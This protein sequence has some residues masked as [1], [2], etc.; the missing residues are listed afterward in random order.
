MT[1]HIDHE[2]IVKSIFQRN[3]KNIAN[4]KGIKGNLCHCLTA[5]DQPNHG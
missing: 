5:G 4:F 1:E 3:H 2:V